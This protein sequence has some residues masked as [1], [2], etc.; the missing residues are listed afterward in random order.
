[1]SF[2]SLCFLSSF[3]SLPHPRLNPNSLSFPLCC[4]CQNPP[5]SSTSPSPLAFSRE[6][7]HGIALPQANSSTKIPWEHGGMAGVSR[8]GRATARS[9]TQAA[10]KRPCVERENCWGS[11]SCWCGHSFG[12][13]SS[14]GPFSPGFLELC[15][16]WEELSA[17]LVSM[18]TQSLFPSE[19]PGVRAG[20][21]KQALVPF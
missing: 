15:L 17:G 11:P 16:S 7:I 14:A 19:S 12:S 20:R 3:C 18:L 2:S 6:V 21:W 9:C 1:M 5:A 8:A 4:S 13:H 10:G